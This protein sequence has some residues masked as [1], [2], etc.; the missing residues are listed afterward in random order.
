MLGVLIVAGALA[1]SASAAPAT[2]P[3]DM[4]ASVAPCSDP[5]TRECRR[6]ER[7]V[8]RAQA[9]RGS[10]RVSGGEH[11]R[12]LT[13]NRFRS[14]RAWFA[15]VDGRRRGRAI[16]ADGRGLAVRGARAR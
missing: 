7:A 13:G 15:D 5:A 11:L 10:L 6:S 3:P 12:I 4:Q 14:T 1:A 16:A 2:S 8:P 9:L